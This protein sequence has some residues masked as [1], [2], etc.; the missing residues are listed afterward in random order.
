MIRFIMK[1]FVDERAV[2][3]RFTETGYGIRNAGDFF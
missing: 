1:N 3:M 2:R